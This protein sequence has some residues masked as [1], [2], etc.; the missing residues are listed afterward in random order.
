[1]VS[2]MKIR[3][4]MLSAAC[5]AAVMP[6]LASP[7]A[8]QSWRRGDACRG[9][10][11]RDRARCERASERCDDRWDR[12]RERERNRRNDA[13][14]QGIVAGVVGTAILGGIIA[15]AASGNKKRG[16]DGR[17]EECEERYGNYDER[18]DSYRASDGRLYPCS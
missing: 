5:S 4:L 9:L 13:K 12:R 3:A 2:H 7:A 6:P 1:M 15:A 14:T 16:N 11:G 8:A 18:S 17:R 10:D